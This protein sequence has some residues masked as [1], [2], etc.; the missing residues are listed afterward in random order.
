MDL[1]KIG[2]YIAGKRKDCGLTQ[3]Q[4][5]EKLGMSDKSVS[6]WERGICLPDVSVYTELC[7]ILG[8][9]LNEFLAGEDLNAENFVLKSEDNLIRVSM[10]GK[11]EKGKLKKMVM[12]LSVVTVILLSVLIVM[13]GKYVMQPANYVEAFSQ[14]S[15]VMKT[16]Q[17]LSGMDGAHLYE[18]KSD[19]T[20]NKMTVWLTTFEHG[21]LI[22]KEKIAECDF[23]HSQRE[24]ILAMIPDF[25]HFKIHFTLENAEYKARKEIDILEGVAGR[26]NFGRT[27]DTIT[28]LTPIHSEDA[29][30]ILALFYGED[31][32]D[33]AHVQA[34]TEGEDI[35]NTDYI[36]LFFI[37]YS[38]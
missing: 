31:I 14:D 23:S 21:T 28:G 10:D 35:P 34:L 9:S 11:K 36:Y 17:L 2:K 22:H 37:R 13:L 29:I 7:G 24:G 25:D 8:I 32:V 38:K 4:L 19:G 26:E 6:K 1:V 15:T 27:S 3:V 30:G 18:Y 12:L 20:Y 16:A 5:A 33:T